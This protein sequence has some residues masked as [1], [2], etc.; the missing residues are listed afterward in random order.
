[1]VLTPS[2]GDGECLDPCK[3]VQFSPPKLTELPHTGTNWLMIAAFALI[4]VGIGLMMIQYHRRAERRKRL[5]S[6]KPR[7][8]HELV[9]HIGMMHGYFALDEWEVDGIL[10]EFTDFPCSMDEVEITRQLHDFFSRPKK[11]DHVWWR[12]GTI[13][14]DPRY[15]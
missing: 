12:P 5:V 3:S 11:Q 7:T 13:Q 15:L 1:M 9:V 10:L 4:A 6:M 2:P 8:W 14:P